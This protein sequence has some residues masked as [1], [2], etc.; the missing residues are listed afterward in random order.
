MLHLCITQQTDA[1]WDSLHFVSQYH[2]IHREQLSA[3]LLGGGFG[4]VEWI[5]LPES[6]FYQPIIVEKSAF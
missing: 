1:G 6:G 2:R 3:I 4:K 5:M